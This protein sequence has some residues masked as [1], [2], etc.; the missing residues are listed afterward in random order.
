MQSNVFTYQFSR[1]P[2]MHV[3]EIIQTPVGAD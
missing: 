2:I 1:D 3:N